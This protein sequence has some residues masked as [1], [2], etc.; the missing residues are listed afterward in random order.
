MARKIFTEGAPTPSLELPLDLEARRNRKKTAYVPFPIAA[1]A[2]A[3]KDLEPVGPLP[4]GPMTIGEALSYLKPA[5]HVPA[6]EKP[7]RD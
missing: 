3:L 1:L 4:K 5:T 6:E 7:Q 2:E